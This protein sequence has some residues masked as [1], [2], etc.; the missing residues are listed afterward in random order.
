MRDRCKQRLLGWLGERGISHV[1]EDDWRDL[2]AFMAPAGKSSV[3]SLLRQAGIGIDQ[4]FAGILQKTFSELE[5]SL[6][7]MERAYATALG[8]GNLEGAQTCRAVVI[9][10]KD[11]AKFAARNPRL[12]VQSRTRKQ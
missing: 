5:E 2:L 9:E 11:R 3:R 6:I 7:Q 4:P 8:A 12:S 1:N 10:A